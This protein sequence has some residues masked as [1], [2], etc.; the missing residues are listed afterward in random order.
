MHSFLISAQIFDAR[1]DKKLEIGKEQ[2]NVGKKDR[3]SNRYLE[4]KNLENMFQQ[5]K[6]KQLY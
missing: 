1:Y 4:T 5:Q 6:R 2:Q 3:K